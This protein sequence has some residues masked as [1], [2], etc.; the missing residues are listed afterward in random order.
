MK[1]ATLLALNTFTFTITLLVNYLGG[2]GTLT[3]KSVGEISAK[4]PSL[5]TPA[6]YAF[7]IWGII[8]LFLL[9]F[10]GFQWHRYLK[11]DNGESLLPSGLWFSA[12]NIFNSVWLLLWLHEELA[13]TVLVMFLLLFSLIRLVIRLKLEI[14]NAPLKIIAF[15]WWPI[16]IYIGWIVLATPVNLAAWL[17]SLGVLENTLPPKV[18]AII[19]ISLAT[20]I[21]LW[22]I[23]KRNMRE[24]ALVGV[25]G[26]IAIAVNQWQS[27][28][29]IGW[30]ALTAAALLFSASGYHA[31]INRA[32]SPFAKS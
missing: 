26:L 32:S 21:Y 31:Y 16:C 15:V 3:G 18:W 19:V 2:S 30:A 24:A 22:L 7:S 13:L 29:I 27:Q 14:W 4:Y 9:G 11:N 25:W 6:A 23:Q 8:Y 20:G 1:P 17:T 12:S 5:I 28:Q 10:L